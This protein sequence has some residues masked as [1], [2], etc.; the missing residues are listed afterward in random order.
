MKLHYVLKGSHENP[1]T[2]AT[3]KTSRQQK[4]TP[5]TYG[6]CLDFVDTFVGKCNGVQARRGGRGR[7]EPTIIYVKEIIRFYYHHHHYY[8]YDYDY[9]VRANTY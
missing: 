2:R 5:A 7:G 4:N 8:D 3:K 9:H 6:F 1:W